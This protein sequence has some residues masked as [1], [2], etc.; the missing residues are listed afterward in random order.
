MIWILE[1]CLLNK[2]YMEYRPDKTLK[3]LAAQAN[4]WC[5]ISGMVTEADKEKAYRNNCKEFYGLDI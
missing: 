3:R 2:T 5:K 4:V 1:V